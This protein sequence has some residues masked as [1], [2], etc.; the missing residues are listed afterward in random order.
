MTPEEYFKKR[1]EVAVLARS[2]DGCDYYLEPNENGID[3][4][5]NVGFDIDWIGYDRRITFNPN[6]RWGKRREIEWT[7]KTTNDQEVH[8]WNTDITK[9]QL[10]TADGEL[11]NIWEIGRYVEASRFLPDGW[12]WMEHN[13]WFTVFK[14]KPVLRITDRISVWHDNGL[15]HPSEGG[16]FQKYRDGDENGKI[17]RTFEMLY[18]NGDIII[19]PLNPKEYALNEDSAWRP[20]FPRQ[21]R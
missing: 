13:G 5:R 7:G 15:L 4:F 12:E 2:P 11:L 9:R 17:P 21:V 8:S 19:H 3:E 6:F 1:P 20:Y 18:P 14:K 16:G 10:Y